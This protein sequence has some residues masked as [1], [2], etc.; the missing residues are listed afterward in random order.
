MGRSRKLDKMHPFTR[1]VFDENGFRSLTEAHRETGL[2][3][4]SL[5]EIARFDYTN[6]TLSLFYGLSRKLELPLETLLID[7]VDVLDDFGQSE[8][9]KRTLQF[10]LAASRLFKQ[11]VTD[12][13][14]GL[15]NESAQNGGFD[16]DS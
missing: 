1:R 7:A 16:A 3:L 6:E 5:C 12:W 2:P 10:H 4:T 15:L 14:L 13:V 9:M 8:R 11:D